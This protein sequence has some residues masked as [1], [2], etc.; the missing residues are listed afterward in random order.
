M[1]LQFLFTDENGGLIMLV[2]KRKNF[3]RIVCK[4]LGITLTIF[5]AKSGHV[6]LG[7]EAPPEIRFDR[8]EIDFARE[9]AG[10]SAQVV[11]RVA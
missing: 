3:E 2:L 10:K 6:K 5:E 7:I 11:Q 8:E 1:I 9:R 4:Q